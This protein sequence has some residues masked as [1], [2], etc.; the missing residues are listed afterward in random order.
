M[1]TIYKKNTLCDL[2]T[3]PTYRTIIYEYIGIIK[4][5]VQQTKIK[6]L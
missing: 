6:L 4:L 3:I 2:Q 5:E 1:T